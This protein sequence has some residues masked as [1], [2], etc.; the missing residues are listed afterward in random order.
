MTKPDF[1]PVKTCFIITPIGDDSSA[2]R[3][4]IDG[5][6]D[7]VITP[8]LDEKGVEARVAH[9]MITSSLI[10]SDVIREIYDATFCIANLTENNP[11]VMY[12][13][14]F[15]H[16]IKKHVIHIVR[17]GSDIPFDLSQHRYIPYV[18]DIAGTKELRERLSVFVKEVLTPNSNVS[19]PIVE[20]LKTWDVVE[21]N[22]T[23]ISEKDALVKILEQLDKQEKMLYITG[24]RLKNLE[25]RGSMISENEIM[26]FLE[27]RGLEKIKIRSDNTKDMKMQNMYEKLL[28]ETEAHKS[29]YDSYLVEK[30]KNGEK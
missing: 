17:K 1:A 28:M 19:N 13:L 10:T 14:S 8:M 11:N 16:A 15:A 18:N 21:P 26:S 22:H 29:K 20:A 30:I 23:S 12:E 24:N 2:I 5:I 4:E 7:E 3:R 6:I 25:Y 27:N 9:R